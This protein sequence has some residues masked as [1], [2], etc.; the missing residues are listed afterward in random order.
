M[1]NKPENKLLLL[2]ELGIPVITS[3]TPAYKRVMDMAGIHAYCDSESVWVEKLRHFGVGNVDVRQ[4]YMKKAS[5]YL[6]DFHTKQ[7]LLS[8]WNRIFESVL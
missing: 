8:N 2:W 3:A 7:I 4:E 1:W 6:E 5:T